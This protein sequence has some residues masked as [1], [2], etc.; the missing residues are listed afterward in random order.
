MTRVFLTCSDALRLSS[1][2]CLSL[3]ASSLS[4]V[5]LPSCLLSP[6]TCPSQAC[7]FKF[8]CVDTALY[9]LQSHMAP[10]A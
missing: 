9:A 5:T 10:Y 1:R 4:A 3:S 7:A 8:A 2:V 6:A